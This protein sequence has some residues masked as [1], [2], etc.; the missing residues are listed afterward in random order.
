[1][2]ELDRYGH[3][4]S[5]S[6][7][8]IA[9]GGTLGI[10]IPPSVVL[11]VYA[12]STEQNIAKLFQAALVP[13]L[14]ATLFYCVAIALVVRRNPALA[15]VLPRLPW[16]ERIPALLA[17]WPTFMIAFIVLGG[18]HAGLFTPTEGASVGVVAMLATGLLMRRLDRERILR[19]LRNTAQTTA[20]IFLILLG[21]EVF[22]AFLALTQ[23]TTNLAEWISGLGLSAAMV[24][25]LLLFSYILLGAVMDELAMIILTL[26]VYFPL[27]QALDLGL[28][29]D[30][31]ALWFGV[32]VLIVVGIGLTAPPMGLNVFVVSAI[33]RH[34]PLADTY[35][36]VM[37]YVAADMLRLGLVFSFPA[38][39]LGLM[40]WTG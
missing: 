40:R 1:L 37:P 4:G 38:L 20:M 36:G 32:L 24:V 15:P 33:A 35:R 22:N 21:G 27:V 26:P 5:F 28:S 34:V 12:I 3:A 10:L 6:T 17:I 19:S 25:A 29:P 14:L 31:A 16:R 8:T 30:D 11:V 18:I 13:G 23:M 9:A 7:G 2:P 39:A